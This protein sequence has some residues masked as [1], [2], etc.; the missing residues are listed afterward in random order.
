MKFLTVGFL[1]YYI[2]RLVNQNMFSKS[3]LTYKELDMMGNMDKDLSKR[4]EEDNE[5]VKKGIKQVLQ[6]IFILLPIMIAEI[7]YIFNALQYGNK[8]ITVGYL[9]FWIILL[10]ISMVKAKIRTKNKIDIST[11][12]SMITMF[13]TI[14]DIMY[15]GYMTYVFFI[16]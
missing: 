14:I 16:Q 13:I 8:T 1:L 3:M 5:I 15:F 2:I 4:T 7:F 6:F 11:K 12:F 9:M 10:I